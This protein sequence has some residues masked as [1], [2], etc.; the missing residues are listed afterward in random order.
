MK[1]I[2]HMVLL[3]VWVC[4]RVC[5]HSFQNHRPE[6][7]LRVHKPDRSDWQPP[8]LLQHMHSSSLLS[9]HMVWSTHARTH[10]HAQNHSV[11]SLPL[12]FKPKP[13]VLS[14]SCR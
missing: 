2:V 11:V 9:Y 6:G 5:V 1:T 7:K 13:D 14:Q 12:G 4:A 10:R 8:P 3:C